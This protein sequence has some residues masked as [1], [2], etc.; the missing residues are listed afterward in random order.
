[1]ANSPGWGSTRNFASMKKL[2]LHIGVMKTG[3][4]TIQ[5][6]LA[7]SRDSL[8]AKGFLY[9]RAGLL[10]PNGNAHHRLSFAMLK[11]YPSYAP[12]A[13]NRAKEE[14]MEELLAEVHASAAT[15]VI[16]SSETFYTAGSEEMV[17][18]LKNSLSDFYVR[19]VVY[20]RRPDL[21]FESWYGQSVKTGNPSTAD[22]FIESRAHSFLP[23]VLTYA[24]IFGNDRMIVRIYDREK[25]V[26][27]DVLSDFLSLIG[28]QTTARNELPKMRVNVGLARSQIK[29]L[30]ELSGTLELDD[31]TRRRL[32]GMLTRLFTYEQRRRIMSKLGKSYEALLDRFEMRN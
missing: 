29:L 18:W 16:V 27:G 2:F 22:E 6:Y 23:N 8:K 3:S 13:W 10:G 31:V 24:D 9:P 28:F 1:M 12:Q 15:K 4:S 17:S 5:V 32:Y 19:V 14:V 30:R 7:K 26:G 20:V 11:Q 21:W 25:L